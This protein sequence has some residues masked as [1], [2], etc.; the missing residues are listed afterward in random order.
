M[1]EL[2][3]FPSCNMGGLPF[4]LR[5][6]PTTAP[7]AH[8]HPSLPIPPRHFSHA[9]P[10]EQARAD[11]MGETRLRACVRALVTDIPPLFAFV[12]RMRFDG[13]RG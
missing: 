1:W 2:R 12:R 11:A 13:N 7:L 6:V 8:R 10:Y 3:A 5:R 9:Y 4:L